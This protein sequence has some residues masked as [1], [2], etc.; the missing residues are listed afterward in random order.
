MKKFLLAGV[1]FSAL[2]A[3]PALAAD[4]PVRRPAPVYRAPV[5]TYY[6]WTGC[7][8]GGHAGSMWVQKDWSVNAADPFF[9]A[10]QSFG[11]HD[12]NGWL[13]GAQAGCNYQVGSWVFGLQ[14][15]YA[16]TDASATSAD[17]LN[18][19]GSTIGSKVKGLGSITGRVGYAWDRVLGYV[20]GGGAWERDEYTMT[21]PGIIATGS[22]TRSGWT[23]GIG[24]E[25]AFTYNFT[26]F[27]EYDYYGFGT[28]A[29]TF[30][31]QFGGLWDI[32][33]I[34]ENKSVLKIGVNWKFGAGP[35]VANY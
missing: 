8:I 12:A 6:S 10:G 24:A 7:Y 26:G 28:K 29:H 25:Y 3:A 11:S 18:G 35:I 17:L 32:A 14:G 20:K 34:K 15:D 19:P 23:V 22:D 1:A 33:D 4:I 31:T 9:F 13:G 16:W 2:V 30:N 5:V 27:I 21:A